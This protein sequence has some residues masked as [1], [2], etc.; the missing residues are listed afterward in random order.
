M[1]A[2]QRMPAERGPLEPARVEREAP[3]AAQF[4]ARQPGPRAAR[5]DARNG[6]VRDPRRPSASPLQ[7]DRETSALHGVR[8]AA[9]LQDVRHNQPRRF[10]GT[11]DAVVR[12]QRWWRRRL[13][14]PRIRT[15]RERCGHYAA[16]RIQ[17]VWRL[18][19]WRKLFVHFS[20]YN[21]GWLGTIDW[22]KRHNFL[23]GTELAEP[24]DSAY[25]AQR[26]SE[27]PLDREVDPWGCGKMQEHMARMWNREHE[28]ERRD[29]RHEHWEQGYADPR[30]WNGLHGIQNLAQWNARLVPKSR[31]LSQSPPRTTRTLA[32]DKLRSAAP[33]AA[34]PTRSPRST[35]GAGVPGRAPVGYGYAGAPPIARP[36]AAGAARPSSQPPRN[37]LPDRVGP[38]QRAQHDAAA[39]KQP[40]PQRAVSSAG[41]AR[42]PGQAADPRGLSRG[43]A[44]PGQRMLMVRGR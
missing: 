43:P 17:R 29:H 18:Y 33:Y 20:E 25:W 38:S 31:V 15:K 27:A 12:V 35:Q 9:G 5:E 34:P 28:I 22:L 3:H 39:L 44:P 21:V 10:R 26:K 23:Y 4:P 13:R 14:R 19:K 37:S 11:T 16:Y 42:M 30:A 1:P 36:S 32:A 8:T 2:A 40:R 7:R 6:L 24:C 41:P